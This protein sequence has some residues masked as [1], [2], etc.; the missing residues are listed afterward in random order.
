VALRLD[1]LAVMAVL[2]EALRIAA[3]VTLSKKVARPTPV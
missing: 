1:A 3:A 2:G